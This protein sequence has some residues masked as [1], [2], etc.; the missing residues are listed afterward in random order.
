MKFFATFPAGL[1]FVFGW[2]AYLLLFFPGFMTTDTVH[3]LLEGRSGQIS[4]WHT[5]AMTLLFGFVDKIYPGPGG[6]LVIQVTLI[7]IALWSFYRI[8]IA[9]YAP[10]LGAMLLVALMFYPAVLGINGAVWK[11]TLMAGFVVVLAAAVMGALERPARK[12]LMTAIALFAGFAVLLLRLNGIFLVFPLMAALTLAYLP[13]RGLLAMLGALTTGAAVSIGL[14]LSAMALSERLATKHLDAILSVAIFDISGTIA[15]LPEGDRQEALFSQLPGALTNGRNAARLA[16][17]YNSRDWTAVFRDNPPGF[18]DVQPF[19]TTYV[20]GFSALTEPER[21]A[22]FDTW[23]RSITTEPIAY[24]THRTD[25]FRWVTGF[26]R[27][28]WQPSLLDPGGYPETL[29]AVV[30]PFS[31][32][33]RLQAALEGLF[34]KLSNY[35]PYKPWFCLLA[36]ALLLAFQLVWRRDQIVPIA[37]CISVV[38]HMF[39]LFL[40][41]PTPD[42]RYSHIIF[43]LTG[44]AFA[45]TLCRPV[46]A[47]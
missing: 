16:A 5:P 20:A 17:T 3:Q 18:N 28:L 1:M 10:R 6:M 12:W 9:D 15:N 37:I 19:R 45:L 43:I 44:L 27:Y 11:D 26:G 8:G 21:D 4:D 22:L 35:P 42:F 2:A 40:L 46:R 30:A 14:T 41:A 38:A 31:A 7:W 39:G 36:A 23:I 34:W 47:P 29:Q 24:L 25:V 32:K 33:T 13:H